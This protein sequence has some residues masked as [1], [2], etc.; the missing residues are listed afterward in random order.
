MARRSW[1]APTLAIVLPWV[2]QAAIRP[3]PGQAT[4]TVAP[5]SNPA[6]PPAGDVL[7]RT[8]SAHIQGATLR[9]V[10]A[11]I[12]TATGAR[13]AFS[14]NVVS[15]D[16]RVNLDASN[17]SVRDALAVLFAHTGIAA[18]P[19]S[20]GAIR[21][22]ARVS[23][24]T[25][26]IAG[27]VLD[28]LSRAVAGASVIVVGNTRF[29]A[30][31]NSDGS[32]V[33]SGLAAG[34]YRLH[35]HF[36]GF[37]DDTVSIIVVGG[38]TVTQNI[39]LRALPQTL[40]TVV[41]TSPRLNETKA[42]AL[43]EQK[44]ADNVVS[45]MSG[46]EIRALPNNNAAEALA[47]MPG[48]TAERDE[49]EGKYVEIRG[50]PPDFQHV[51]ID[52][53]DVPGTLATD[54]RAVKLDDVPA[55]ILGAI[56]VNKT[57]SADMDADAI[58]G[59]VNLV[60]KVPEGPVRGYISGM[61]GYQ[62]LES[63]N[64]GHGDLSYG[65]RLGSSQKFGFLVSGSIDRTDRVIND[66]E[67]SFTGEIPDG[68]GGFMSV[69]G[70][71]YSHVQVSS[72]SQREYNYYRTRYG[73]AEDLDY[74]FSPT[75]SVY[76][77]GLWSAFFDE[78][79]RWETG[80]S[81]GGDSLIG[82]VPTAT[83]ASVTNTVSNRGPIE[84][85]WGFT[86]GGRQD[87][88]KV[89]LTYA[90]NYAGSTANQHAHFEDD[91]N[92]P[93]GF[94]YTY[95]A[96][97]LIPRYFLD[98]A[99]S[100]A[101]ASPS[102]WA[103][104]QLGTDYEQNSGQVVGG[105]ADALL[106]YQIGALP[107]STKFGVKVENQHKGYLSF[108][109]DYVPNGNLTLAQFMSNY[110]DPGFYGHIC[111]GCYQLAPFG[112]LPAVNQN[113]VRNP[114]AWTLQSNG[115]SDSGATFA[116]TEEVNSVY[117]MQTLDVRKLHI[118][119]G[120]RVENTNVGYVGYQTVTGTDSQPAISA[121][122]VHGNNSYTDVFP[123]AQLKYALDDNTNVRVAFTR[124]IARPDYVQL[125][126]SVQ[127]FDAVPN[128]ITQG[129]SLGNPDLKPEHAW[130]YDLLAEHYFPSVGVLSGG[131]FYKS[132]TD[133][134]FTRESLYNGPITQYDGF[135]ATQPQNGPTATLWGFELDYMQ[136][137]TFLPGALKGI[138][139]D[140]N[141]THVESRAIVPQDTVA[142]DV[143]YTDPVTGNT[144]NQ[145]AGQPYRHAPIPRQ[146]PNMYNVAALYDYGSVTARVSGQYTA[147]SIYQYGSNGTSNPQNGDV[148]NY[149][150]WQVDAA[151]TWIV[152]GESALTVQA[153]DINNSVFG[154][155]TG[156]TAHPWNA[157]REYYGT[158]ISIGIRQGF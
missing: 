15:A 114:N 81:A 56:E 126:P 150:H 85:T 93:S 32:Y 34:P 54:V 101:I 35:A 105:K 2:A 123:S 44:D 128:S 103:L 90:A 136:H 106:P 7:N 28:T 145:F 86:G 79:N 6:S 58:G 12:S 119:L 121:A 84:H 133:F 157:Q 122:R 31:A 88:G 146:F 50:T 60:T 138:G 104:T 153:L 100:S 52:G 127:A 62:S 140:V 130:N 59:T 116:G 83:G 142:A 124:G 147:A 53:A 8:F 36:I 111:S 91:Y 148:W 74:R 51:T 38:Q 76:I 26:T 125:A 73:L 141:Y 80:L 3:L 10:L 27:R 61:Y 24:E 117:L 151:L 14:A 72:L 135:Y 87:V 110:T 131:V 33:I 19:S 155:F 18:I 115:L 25:G 1:L 156:T 99:T 137:L 67:P 9:D 108:Q 94:N 143:A 144:I 13:F 48:V 96:N 17:L 132:I 118:N 23:E 22:E 11:V 71:T 92:G 102:Q 152:F 78:A 75:S 49:G 70:S 63:N 154:F 98:A 82:G 47:R 69:P 95:D 68:Q 46:D 113:L 107:A 42:G 134:I 43:Q 57:L 39:V 21:L 139:F 5:T 149:P 120:V 37:T 41:V 16:R 40:N 64:N 158:T 112:S 109:P 66:V 29:A 129:V 20:S 45:V 4:V 97:R 89:H 77:K 55:D 65:G 30:T